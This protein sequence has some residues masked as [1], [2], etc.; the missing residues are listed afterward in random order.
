MKRSILFAG[1]AAMSLASVIFAAEGK[2]PAANAPGSAGTGT[3]VQVVEEESVTVVAAPA[4][5]ETAPGTTCADKKKCAGKKQCADKKQCAGKKCPPSGGN[6]AQAACAPEPEYSDDDYAVAYELM[7]LCNEPQNIENANMVM[8]EAQMQQMP[9]LA[10]AK[11]AFHNF[12]KKHCSY[13]AMKKDLAK[14]HLGMFTRDELK[15][16]IAFFKTPEGK[17]LAASHTELMNKSMELREKRI[18]DN[19]PELQKN[20]RTAMEASCSAPPQPPVAQAQPQN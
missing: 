16:I 20:V 13:E 5:P 11:P 3:P 9:M 4:A 12:F 19:L 8:I 18:G 6:C 15:K 10:P 1:A 7:E 2:T 17:K 14:I